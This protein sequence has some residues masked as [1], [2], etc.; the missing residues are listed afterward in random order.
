MTQ[1]PPAEAG[2][3]ELR[4]E[5]PDGLQI[6]K[7]IDLAKEAQVVVSRKVFAGVEIRIGPKHFEIKQDREGGVFKLGDMGE[8]VFD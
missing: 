4:T 2:G 3:F 8:I 6:K 5:S 1:Q 7:E